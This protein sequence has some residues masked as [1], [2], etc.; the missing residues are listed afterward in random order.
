M[1]PTISK[2]LTESKLQDVEMSDESSKY[3]L[4][5]LVNF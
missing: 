5:T 2:C 3:S 1:G 4:L